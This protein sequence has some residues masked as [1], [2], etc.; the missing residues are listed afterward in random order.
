MPASGLSAAEQAALEAENQRIRSQNPDAFAEI[1]KVLNDDKLFQQKLAESKAA[2]QAAISSGAQKTGSIGTIDL[3][4]PSTKDAII[5]G[6]K[7]GGIATA[8]GG[9]A[10]LLVKKFWRR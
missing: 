9:A 3:G 10:V 8:I 7:V 1:D 4:A 6:L 5:K 2:E